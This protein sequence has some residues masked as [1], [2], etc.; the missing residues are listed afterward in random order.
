MVLCDEQGV[1]RLIQEFKYKYESMIFE[2]SLFNGYK[3]AIPAE[4]LTDNIDIM[5]R[6]PSRMAE[7]EAINNLTNYILINFDMFKA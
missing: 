5:D 3:S 6:E 2:F 4:A 7:L 1:P